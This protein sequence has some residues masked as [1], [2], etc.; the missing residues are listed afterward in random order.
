[1]LKWEES[2]VIDGEIE[3]G[4]S[5]ERRA[6]GRRASAITNRTGAE[7][8]RSER[9]MVIKKNSVF[10][11]LNTLL[12]FSSLDEK[13]ISAPLINNLLPILMLVFLIAQNKKW[14]NKKRTAM[15]CFCCCCL[16]C[17]VWSQGK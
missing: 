11:T 3:T 5:V 9:I 15:Y 1:M 10:T 12:D 13:P 6:E 7:K 17:V 16:L 2:V 14:K 4:E 8:R